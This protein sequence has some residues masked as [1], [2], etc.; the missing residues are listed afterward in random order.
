MLA[1]SRLFIISLASHEPSEKLLREQKAGFFQLH[2]SHY[3]SR[4]VAGNMKNSLEVIIHLI[5]HINFITK[6]E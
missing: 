2:C 5:G 3:F 6:S 1:P 4:V